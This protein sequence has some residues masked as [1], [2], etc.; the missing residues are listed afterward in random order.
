MPYQ[1]KTLEVDD[2]EARQP[3]PRAGSENINLVMFFSRDSEFVYRLELKTGKSAVDASEE[4]IKE[5]QKL[6]DNILSTFQFI[7]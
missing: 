1:V 3:L 4:D 6:F 2:Q 7:E 5:G